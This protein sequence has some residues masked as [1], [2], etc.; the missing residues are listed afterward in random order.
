M[1]EIVKLS[2]ETYKELGKLSFN[3]SLL[4]AGTVVVSPMVKGK[5]EKMTVVAGILI[6]LL[7]LLFGVILMER[8]SRE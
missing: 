4:I 6:A 8:G 1:K 2:K 5:I 7:F 3:L